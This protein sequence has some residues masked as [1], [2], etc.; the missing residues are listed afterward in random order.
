MA[1]RLVLLAMQ[2][3]VATTQTLV[4]C[5]NVSFMVSGAEGSDVV[6]ETFSKNGSVTTP[7]FDGTTNH[8]FADAS[9]Y[10][11]TRTPRNDEAPA[12]TVEITY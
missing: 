11:V 1:K 2:G 3:N 4:P 5:S 6:L 10:T 9:Y 8:T 7:L 12:T